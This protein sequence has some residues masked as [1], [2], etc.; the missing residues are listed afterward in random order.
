[1]QQKKFVGIL[2][3]SRESALRL[4]G[5]N[6]IHNHYLIFSYKTHLL[7]QAVRAAVILPIIVLAL[8]TPDRIK[9]SEFNSL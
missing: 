6:W 7:E 2:K 5:N 8:L 1:M 3:Y 4:I 9:Q